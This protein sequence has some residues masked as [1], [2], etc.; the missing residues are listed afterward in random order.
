NSLGR[1]CP[2]SLL[3]NGLGSNVS[4]WLGPPAMNR[5]ITA[6]AF[7]G[8]WG[9]F[10]AS[11]SPPPARTCSPSRSEARARP[12]KPQNA[13]RTNS[14]RVRVGSE[15]KWKHRSGNI[16]E[17]IQVEHSQ[18]EFFDGLL[19]KELDRQLTLRFG[20]RATQPQ[21]EST[22]HDEIRRSSRLR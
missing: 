4:R 3:S 16:S 15:C 20:R 18:C 21:Q 19:T 1:V 11:G 17:P 10:A 7:A 22:G 14:R 5:K 8:T 6:F 2:S 13:S 12:L 9:S